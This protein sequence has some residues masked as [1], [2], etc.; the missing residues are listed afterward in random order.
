M[1]YCFLAGPHVREPKIL[2]R[3]ASLLRDRDALVAFDRK[4][5]GTDAF[6]PEEWDDYEAYWM[7]A[8]GE[9][10]GCCAF[11]PDVDL[12]DHQRDSPPLLGSL[13][14]VSTGIL[15]EYQ[16]KGF[17]EHFKRWQIGW[18]QQNGFWQ[19]VTNSRKSNRPMIA[20]NQKVGFRLA[21]TSTR[22]YCYLPAEKAVAMKLILP[23]RKGQAA[24]S[25]LTWR[26]LAMLAEQRN[27][28]DRAI[29]ALTASGPTPR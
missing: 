22:N 10:I 9:R 25:V 28:F 20:L 29:E 19:I 7:I 17:G 6:D 11:K 27:R 12:R 3:R 15:P 21:W 16:G 4:V 13:Y 1:R 5:F 24:R 2:F 18:A 14:I 23:K 26:I 8:N